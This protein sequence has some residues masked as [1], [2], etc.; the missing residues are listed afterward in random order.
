MLIQF[1]GSW[2]TP[3]NQVMCMASTTPGISS[4]SAS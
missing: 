3:P 2:Y 1:D 4:M